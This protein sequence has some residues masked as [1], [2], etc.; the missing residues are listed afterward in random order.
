MRNNGV[1]LELIESLDEFDVFEEEVGFFEEVE[2][3]RKEIHGETLVGNAG[4]VAEDVRE[5]MLHESKGEQVRDIHVAIG[6]RVDCFL[7][8]VGLRVDPL[9]EELRFR[10][11]IRM[12][13]ELVPQRV[14]V[15]V[16]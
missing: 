2:E 8:R 15:I 10:C 11:V 16:R 1:Y 12:L 6:L 9:Q 14:E 4:R 3:D 13:H 5:D 7:H